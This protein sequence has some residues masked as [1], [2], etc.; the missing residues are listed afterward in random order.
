MTGQP[1]EK[2]ASP[3]YAGAWNLAR[4]AAFALVLNLAWEGAQTPLY[5]IYSSGT[6]REIVFAIIHCTAGDVLISVTCFAIGLIAT[7]RA[8]WPRTRPFS[9]GMVVLLSGLAYTAFSEWWNVYGAGNWSYAPAMPM[10][11]GI[12]IAPLL[13]WAIIPSASI[14][15]LR[16]Y[17]GN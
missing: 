1:D 14:A 5:T 2:R 4:W 13:Q 11:F 9:G 8:D 7:R 6:P 17:P 16:K 12:G 3:R 15:F 10:L